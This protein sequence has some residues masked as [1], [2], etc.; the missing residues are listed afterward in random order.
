MEKI[1]PAFLPQPFL[2][3]PSG[4]TLAIRTLMRKPVTIEE[5]LASKLYENKDSNVSRLGGFVIRRHQEL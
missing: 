3:F 2:Y 5:P 1:Y 4:S